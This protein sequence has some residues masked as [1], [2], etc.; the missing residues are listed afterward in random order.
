MSTQQRLV[1]LRRDL[2]EY[3]PESMEAVR[4]GLDDLLRILIEARELAQPLPEDDSD[5]PCDD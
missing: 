5:E 3:P 2:R 4:D 1:Q